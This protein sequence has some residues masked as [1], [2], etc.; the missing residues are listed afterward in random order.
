MSQPRRRLPR[1]APKV[2]GRLWRTVGAS[3][4]RDRRRWVSCTAIIRFPATPPIMMAWSMLGK[5][6]IGSLSFLR[7]MIIHI[8]IGP[9]AD[10]SPP[11]RMLRICHGAFCRNA[12]RRSGQLTWLLFAGRERYRPSPRHHAGFYDISPGVCIKPP[13]PIEGLVQIGDMHPS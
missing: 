13:D 8:K 12:A 10:K 2:A 11:S 9:A 5:G 1:G 3:S 4:P 6:S 7:D